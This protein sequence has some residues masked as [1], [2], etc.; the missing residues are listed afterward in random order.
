[1]TGGLD[2][3][4]WSK[5]FLPAKARAVLDA[6]SVKALVDALLSRVS[7]R[8]GLVIRDVQQFSLHDPERRVFGQPRFPPFGPLRSFVSAD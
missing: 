8:A 6:Q 3:T 1:V 2:S 5:R 4:A 7:E